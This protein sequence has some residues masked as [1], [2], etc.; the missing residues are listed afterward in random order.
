MPSVF[1]LGP[2]SRSPYPVV[3][4][5]MREVGPL[6]LCKTPSDKRWDLIVAG[7]VDRY[8]HSLTAVE[9]A[10]DP[11]SAAI[12]EGDPGRARVRSSRC[13]FR[14]PKGSICGVNWRRPW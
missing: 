5:A 13:C 12:Q 9:M 1:G 10:S 11:F 14:Q 6:A 8:G 3:K 7:I 2:W 4:T